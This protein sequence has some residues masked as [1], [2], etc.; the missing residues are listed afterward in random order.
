MLSNIW[1]AC[2]L[3]LAMAIQGLGTLKLWRIY[4]LVKCALETLPLR[5]IWAIA[6]W[7][8]PG[9]VV[10]KCSFIRG[11]NPATYTC[12]LVTKFQ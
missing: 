1:G 9:P 4:P 6:R 8:P 5:L 10:C 2:F 7:I 3:V 11:V 12:F